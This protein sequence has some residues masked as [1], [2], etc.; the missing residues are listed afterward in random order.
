MNLIRKVT[1]VIK[2]SIDILLLETSL[3]FIFIH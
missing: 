2:E 1:N 3:L